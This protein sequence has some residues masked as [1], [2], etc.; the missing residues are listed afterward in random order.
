MIQCAKPL[1]QF[2]AHRDEIIEAVT[3]VLDSGLY[4]LGPEVNSFEKG[5]SQYC[6]VDYAV[7]VNSGTDALILALK[8]M[9][10]GPG[11]EVITVSLTALATISA[12][13]ACGATPVLVDI[14]P[15]YYTMCPKALRKVITQYSKVII[16]VHLYGQCADMDAILSIAAEHNILVIEDCAQATGAKYKTKRVGSIGDAGCFSFYPTKNL[17]AVGDGGAVLTK[18]KAIA[19]RIR[20]L[21]QY[22]WD[23]KRTTIEPGLNSRLDEIQAA[24]LNVKLKYLDEENAK[25]RSLAKEYHQG[26]SQFDIT[27]PIE[28]EN[29]SHVFHLYVILS[30]SRARL[31]SDMN[32]IGIGAGV[33]Y[34]LA[35]HRHGGHEK[36]CRLPEGGLPTTDIIIDSCLSLPMHPQLDFKDVGFVISS[37]T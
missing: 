11:D 30:K 1:A 5:F 29:T 14:D 7:G 20:R 32:E 24:I 37:I 21:R 28:R 19:E 27:L 17:G 33:H 8:A 34:S 12:I 35:A 22:G 13:I 16:P 3:S 15:D 10:V 26:L 6:G 9:E 18:N 31:I 4:V 36:Y 2:Q 23:E 25:R